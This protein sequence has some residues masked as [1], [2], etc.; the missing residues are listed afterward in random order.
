MV[1]RLH[2]SAIFDVGIWPLRMHF[3]FSLVLLVQRM[4]LLQLK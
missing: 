4:L 3:Q 2:S 1:L